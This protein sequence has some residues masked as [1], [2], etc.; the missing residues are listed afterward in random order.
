[1][2]GPW[3][4]ELFRVNE[5]GTLEEVQLLVVAL[6]LQVGYNVL[7]EELVDKGGFAQGFKELFAVFPEIDK[8]FH[9][10]LFKRHLIG[11]SREFLHAGKDR[12][13]VLVDKLLELHQFLGSNI[14]GISHCGYFNKE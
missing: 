9:C 14:T 12:R 5:Q 4:S 13:I 1:M 3:L 7:N 10:K 2:A 6:F 8:D 11:R